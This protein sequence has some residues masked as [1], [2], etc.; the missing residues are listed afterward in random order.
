MANSQVRC[1]DEKDVKMTHAIEELRNAPVTVGLASHISDYSYLPAASV[2]VISY[3][4]DALS[5]RTACLFYL[6]LTVLARQ[7]RQQ[8]RFHVK[9]TRFYTHKC[10]LQSVFA[11]FVQNIQRKVRLIYGFLCHVTHLSANLARCPLYQSRNV[12]KIASSLRIFPPDDA[13]KHK[14]GQLPLAL[15]PLCS[16]KRVIFTHFPAR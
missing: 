15:E 16:K 2:S 4:D 10:E 3:K 5:Y 7:L 9:M 8:G 1:S 13:P 12:A 14:T 6:Y 11:H